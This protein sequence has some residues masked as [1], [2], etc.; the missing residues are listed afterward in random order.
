VEIFNISPF[1]F[2]GEILTVKSS[3]YFTYGSGSNERK[4]YDM[5][6]SNVSVKSGMYEEE[7][8]SEI[9][10]YE[11]KVRVRE[12]PYFNRIDRKPKS[13]NLT[14]AFN[15]SFDDQKLNDVARWLSPAFYEPMIFSDN[16]TKIYYC[17]PIQGS[18]LIHNGL[19]QGYINLTFRCDSPYAYSLP[20]KS[21]IYDLSINPADGTLITLENGGY[22]TIPVKIVFQ[23]V[24]SGN[25]SFRNISSG[26]SKE[27]ALTGLVNGEEIIIDSENEEIN[28]SVTSRYD[29]HNDEFLELYRGNNQ[30]AVKGNMKIYFVYQFKYLV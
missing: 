1:L 3:L 8:M 24:G 26:Y 12:A 19:N 9:D 11:T 17:I 7:F 29:N 21:P 25:I 22:E 27:I 23:K 10:I 6:I 16:P 13:L 14:F 4:S 20:I 30:I 28:S 15:K 5:G 2:G 18:E